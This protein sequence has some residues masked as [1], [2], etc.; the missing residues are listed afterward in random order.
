[1]TAG[2]FRVFAEEA[3]ATLV[4]VREVL[5]G[6]DVISPVAVRRVLEA[7]PDIVIRALYGATEEACSRRTM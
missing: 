3:P 5:T 7:C 6:G 4:G 2:L 1:M